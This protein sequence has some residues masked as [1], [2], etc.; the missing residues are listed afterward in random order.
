[1]SR[2]V[3]R[4]Q[5]GIS[6]SDLRGVQEPRGSAF[7]AAGR[8]LLVLLPGATLPPAGTPPQAFSPG[9]FSPCSHA[10]EMGKLLIFLRISGSG[11]EAKLPDAM[12]C[13]SLSPRCRDA[14]APPS[15]SRLGMSRALQPEV[16]TRTS[17]V[18][19]ARRN[20][21]AP[22]PL[23]SAPPQPPPAVSGRCRSCRI[24]FPFGS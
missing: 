10:G 23:G 4:C 5:A 20:P 9:L 15:C 11:L 14:A 21:S 16:C 2:C 13:S 7:P 24:R 18:A 17:W 6:L 22:V 12:L 19:S 8:R 3:S 1:M